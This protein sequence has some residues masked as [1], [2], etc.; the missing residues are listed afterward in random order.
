MT[1]GWH[2]K[3]GENKESQ[4][5][6]PQPDEKASETQQQAAPRSEAEIEAAERRNTPLET[7]ISP[8]AFFSAVRRF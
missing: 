4:A 6:S 1:N 2:P 3:K 7:G 8:L 5:T